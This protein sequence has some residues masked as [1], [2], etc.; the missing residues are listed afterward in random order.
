[1]QSDTEPAFLRYGRPFEFLTPDGHRLVAGATRTTGRPAIKK[2][3]VDI[4]SDESGLGLNSQQWVLVPTGPDRNQAWVSGAVVRRSDVCYVMAVGV[5]F[6]WVDTCAL[7]PLDPTVV[8]VLV[9]DPAA[10]IE[11]T[12]LEDLVA[13]L[14]SPTHTAPSPS[15]KATGAGA[16][17]QWLVGDPKTAE[18]SRIGAN[19]LVLSTFVRNTQ[20]WFVATTDETSACPGSVGLS[21]KDNPLRIFTS[22]VGGRETQPACTPDVCQVGA[23]Y[24]PSTCNKLG[25]TTKD[26]PLWRLRQLD[27]AARTVLLIAAIGVG[28]AWLTRPRDARA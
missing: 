22:P 19:S 23:F 16:A 2:R 10:R 3:A 12:L 20:E 24:Y 13:L 7:N 21:S 27:K 11:S 8:P 15:V 4:D 6:L 1:M 9:E 5:G 17:S 14:P 25:C 28:A 26:T 18:F